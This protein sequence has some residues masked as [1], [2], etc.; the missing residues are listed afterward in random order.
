[1][2]GG[3]TALPDQ[4]EAKVI[5]SKSS[6]KQ[7]VGELIFKFLTSS[8]LLMGSALVYFILTNKIPFGEKDISLK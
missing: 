5:F 6:F 7:R 8:F 1:M 3:I 2:Y 4:A